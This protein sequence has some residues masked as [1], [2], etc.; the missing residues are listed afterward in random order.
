MVSL[1]P[2]R[3]TRAPHAL[4]LCT[5]CINTQCLLSS[6][7]ST[8]SSSSAA[9]STSSTSPHFLL[10]ELRFKQINLITKSDFSLIILRSLSGCCAFVQVVCQTLKQKHALIKYCS[11]PGGCNSTSTPQKILLTMLPVD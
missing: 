8:T 5:S 9:T 7:T 2:G 3:H 4:Q 11:R 6:L 1:N 10:C